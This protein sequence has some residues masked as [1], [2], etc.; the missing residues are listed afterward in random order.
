MKQIIN[1]LTE[2]QNTYGL[3]MNER[4]QKSY[5]RILAS[6]YLE[7]CREVTELNVEALNVAA[8]AY[9]YLLVEKADD[10]LTIREEMKNHDY[11]W[12]SPAPKLYSDRVEETIDLMP[13]DRDKVLF[14]DFTVS[15]LVFFI[16]SDV[17]ANIY[18]DAF[19]GMSKI[20]NK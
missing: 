14:K 17:Y 20:L 3:T 10:L 4:R 11:D 1:Q 5:C 13:Y 8:T 19:V 2:I 9:Y 6:Y 18:A 16:V 15:D 7:M 12:D